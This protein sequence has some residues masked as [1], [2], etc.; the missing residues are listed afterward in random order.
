[1]RDPLQACFPAILPEHEL[2]FCWENRNSGSANPYPLPS[3][4]ECSGNSPVN[5]NDCVSSERVAELWTA[6]PSS[7]H[8][9]GVVASFTDGH[10]QFV[11]DTISRNVFLHLMT[12]DG[13]D[14]RAEVSTPLL[15]ENSF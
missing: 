6:R 12:P 13:E 2:G 4:F 10:Q 14:A 8:P 5:I 7:F 11:V 15:D 3:P 1:M 9:G